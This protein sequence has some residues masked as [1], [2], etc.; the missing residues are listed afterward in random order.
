MAIILHL[1]TTYV[2]FSLFFVVITLF[3]GIFVYVLQNYG[4]KKWNLS[5]LEFSFLSFAV[6]I[7]I[8]LVFGY[9]LS[10]FKI[11][12]FYSAYLPFLVMAAGFLLV[13]YRNKTL[14]RIWANLR[15]QLKSNYKQLIALGLILCVIFLFQFITYWPMISEDSALLISDPYYWARHTLYLNQNGNVNYLE[16]GS[17]YPWGFILYCGGNLLISPD[18]TTTYYFMKLAAFPFLNLYVLVM[19]SLSKRLFRAKFLIFFC[20]LAVLSNLYFSFR[21]FIFLSSAL[22]VLLIL[23][24][25]LIF[26][27]DIPN[28]FL[29]FM[30]PVIFLFNPAYLFFFMLAL[31]IFYSYKILTAQKDKLV[32]FK[33]FIKIGLISLMFLSVYGFSVILIYQGNLLSVI[34]YFFQYTKIESVFISFEPISGEVIGGL[35]IFNLI[36]GVFYFITF[37]ILPIVGIFIKTGKKKEDGTKDFYLFI[38]IGVALTFI[39]IFILPH[40]IKT[41]FFEIYYTRILEI[42]FPCLILLSG[43]SLKRLKFF[44]DNLWQKIK[45]SNVKIQKWAKKDNFFSKNLNLPSLVIFFIIL[46]PILNHIYVRDNLEM[47][48]LF[49]DS[50]ITCIFYIENS[51][52]VDSNIGVN[53]FHETHSPIGLLLNYNLSTYSVDFNLTISEF[54]NFTQTNNL[55]YFIMKLSNYNIAFTTQIGNISLYERLAGGTD[56]SEFQLY[57]IL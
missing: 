29:G 30:I 28:Y 7:L 35:E 43:I 15:I 37:L 55:E 24:S 48:Y 44:S 19:F 51:I 3:G 8:Y 2:I 31:V 16:H 49:D 22:S 36:L 14:H 40:F 54:T 41:G 11:F 10:F 42:F 13:L 12:N 1:L 21:V 25:L 27:T 45:L 23:I 6:G 33:E 9:I 38:K 50:I 47:H 26:L 46:L 34:N 5:L 39:I 17:T 18:F 53:G 32:I 56:N 4:K 57:R 20:L 52:E